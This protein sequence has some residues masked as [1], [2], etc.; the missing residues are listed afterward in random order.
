[1]NPGQSFLRPFFIP[2]TICEAR[3]GWDKLL[4]AAYPV[5]VIIHANWAK[6][7]QTVFFSV[8]SQEGSFS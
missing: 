7:R 8:M 3:M 2:A 6:M 4:V 1:M 5:I